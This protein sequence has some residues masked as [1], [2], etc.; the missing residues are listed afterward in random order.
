M[1]KSSGLRGLFFAEGFEDTGQ[2]VATARQSRDNVLGWR[3][4]QTDE[5]TEQFLLAFNGCEAFELVSTD[6][7]AGV[8]ESTLQRGLRL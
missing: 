5:F 3:L 1:R 7:D 8:N 4:E 6:V 2:F